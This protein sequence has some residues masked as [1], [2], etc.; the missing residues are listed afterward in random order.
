RWQRHRHTVHALSSAGSD[1]RK[2]FR[3]RTLPVRCAIDRLPWRDMTRKTCAAW[4]AAAAFALGAMT[5]SFAAPASA[6]PVPSHDK[7]FTFDDTKPVVVA[8]PGVARLCL[9]REQVVRKNPMAPEHLYLD[10][11]PFAYLPQRGVVVADVP[12]GFH[13]LEGVLGCPPL[14]LECPADEV[15]LMRLREVIDEQDA[16]RARWLLEDPDFAG[17]LVE[18]MEL[19]TTTTTP[20]GMEELAKRWRTVKVEARADT[21]RSP[22]DSSTV[23]AVDD[24]W[25]EHPLD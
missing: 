4:T 9:V 20:H 15:V 13:R 24:V 16:V 19:L 17:D 1:P 2:A 10:G 6:A 25:F 14:V 8:T 5:T 18:Q 23:V 12:P 7:R 21:V 11:K 3:N 22:H